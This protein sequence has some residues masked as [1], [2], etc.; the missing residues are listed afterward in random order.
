M[1]GFWN[2]LKA[3]SLTHLCL[4]VG[5]EPGVNWTQQGPPPEP[6]CSVFP[7]AALASS[8]RE[9]RVLCLILGVTCTR[10]SW[11]ETVIESPQVLEEG[12]QTPPLDRRNI[13]SFYI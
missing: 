7:V 6:L 9:G 4:G 5:G 13:N 12:T 1:A 3:G 11:V 10:A 2:S 8:Q